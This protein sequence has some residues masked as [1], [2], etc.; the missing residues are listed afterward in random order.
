MIQDFVSGSTKPFFFGVSS[1]LPCRFRTFKVGHFRL[2]DSLGV[3]RDGKGV[4][5]GTVF[6][7]LMHIEVPVCKLILNDLVSLIIWYIGHWA[8]EIGNLNLQL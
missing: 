2:Q 4:V 3:G 1:M 8:L 5:L 6:N 7:V